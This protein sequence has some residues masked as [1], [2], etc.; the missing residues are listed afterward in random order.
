METNENKLN[1]TD[2]AVEAPDSD[3]RT[4]RKRLTGK[5][6]AHSCYGWL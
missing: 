6:V 3:S 1:G 5:K 2:T 4:N